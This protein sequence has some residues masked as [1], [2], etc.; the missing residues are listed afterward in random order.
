M[1]TETVEAESTTAR[2]ELEADWKRGAG[3]EAILW[4][5][6]EQDF[7][8]T[9]Q[10]HEGHRSTERRP[11]QKSD[12]HSFVISVHATGRATVSWEV[13][14]TFLRRTDHRVLMSLTSVSPSLGIF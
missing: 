7:A 10:P 3:E 2:T 9:S 11:A 8:T 6:L 14:V 1:A 12:I 13:A 4:R 5:R